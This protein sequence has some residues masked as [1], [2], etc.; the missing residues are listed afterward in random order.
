[1]SITNAEAVR[2]YAAKN[3]EKI[4]AKGK[5]Q[6]ELFG[7]VLRAR[8]LSWYRANRDKV[9][10]QKNARRRTDPLARLKNVVR[11]RIWCALK[12]RGYGKRD[13]TV[14]MLGCSYEDLRRHIEVQFTEGMSFDNQGAWHID[15]KI[16]L[17]TAKTEDE[18]I[19]LCHYTN[20]RPL[21]AQDNMRRPRRHV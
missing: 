4:R 8:S 16:Q 10:E 21:W 15:H 2:R 17:A 18:L 7:D 13:R 9:R 5:R 11:T 1:M 6:R 14:T 12:R 20:L 19:A 3:P